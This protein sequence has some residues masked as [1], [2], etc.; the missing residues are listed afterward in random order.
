M[1]QHFL[2][3]DDDVSVSVG[4]AK[5]VSLS[6]FVQQPGVCQPAAQ[7]R[8]R[9][10]QEGQL[11]KVC[12]FFVFIPDDAENQADSETFDFI[13]FPSYIL[14]TFPC[15]YTCFDPRRTPLHYASANCNYQ[16]VFALAGSGASIN[17]LDQRGCSALHYAAAADMDGK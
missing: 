17:E 12:L 2:P 6:V 8:S 15:C 10:Q 3:R 1:R 14:V 5:V 11:W 9:L 16:C 4:V 7:H 13:S